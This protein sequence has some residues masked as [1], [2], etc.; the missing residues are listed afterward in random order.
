MSDQYISSITSRYGD[1]ERVKADVKVL[2]EIIARQGTELLLD[3]VAEYT[4][5]I[6]NKY[7]LPARERGVLRESLIADFTNALEERT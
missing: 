1:V 2:N 5:K 4:A 3:A 7:R 6:V